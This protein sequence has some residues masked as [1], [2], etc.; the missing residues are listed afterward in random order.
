MKRTPLIVILII[1]LSTGAQAA[2]GFGPPQ[3][4]EVH[5][6]PMGSRQLPISTE[7]PYPSRDG[8][9]LFFNTGSKESHKDLHY[10]RLIDGRWV[11]QDE[12]GGVNSPDKVQG[13]PSMDDN[14]LFYYVDVRADAMLK[15]GRLDWQTMSVVDIQEFTAIPKRRGELFRQRI[16]GNMDIEAAADGNTVIVSRATWGWDGRQVKYIQASKL[17]LS[18]RRGE[19]FEFDLEESDRILQNINTEDLEYGAALSADGKELFFTRL[20]SRDLKTLNLRS[21]IMRATRENGDDPFG[22]PQMVESIGDKDFVEGPALSADGKTLYYHQK[23]GK[24][25]RLFRVTRP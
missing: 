8:Q 25:F 6:L 16:H 24:K 12:I 19:K 7:E 14:G 5:N 22:P 11:Y 10:A 3:R 17:L 15:F 9:I 1:T 18:R 23:L 4:V 21:Q 20:A 13:T 2:D